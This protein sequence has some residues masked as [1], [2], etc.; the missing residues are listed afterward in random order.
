M[1]ERV[2]QAVTFVAIVASFSALVAIPISAAA[3]E[4]GRLLYTTD[5][6]RGLRQGI[7]LII[8]NDGPRGKMENGQKPS[9]C[10]DVSATV[11]RIP[12]NAPATMLNP[13]VVNPIGEE[14]VVADSLEIPAK[15]VA[16]IWVGS[17]DNVDGPKTMRVAVQISPASAVSCA[18]NVSAVPADEFGNATGN[19][20]NL[21]GGL[22][23]IHP[24]GR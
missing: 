3:D 16:K 10:E 21:R 14:E 9:P 4:L 6:I 20:I 19:P 22:F 7:L 17:G 24:P 15:S 18:L 5:W 2:Q 1:K 12:Y 11:S 23:Q 8:V 13:V